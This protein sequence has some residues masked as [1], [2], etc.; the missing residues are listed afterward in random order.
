MFG[1]SAA[2]CKNVIVQFTN[3]ICI[4]LRWCCLLIKDTSI[5]ATVYSRQS[6]FTI[7]LFLINLHITH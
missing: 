2:K 6:M 5:V 7:L 4:V 3:K 1:A